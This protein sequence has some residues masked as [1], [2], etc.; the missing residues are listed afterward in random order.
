MYKREEPLH[1]QVLL[2]VYDSIE[3]DMFAAFE[4]VVA[5]VIEDFLE[6]IEPAGWQICQGSSDL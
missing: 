4:Y 6:L 2:L 5:V 1:Y 3:C